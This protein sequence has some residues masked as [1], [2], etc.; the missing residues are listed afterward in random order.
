MP[1]WNVLEASPT[2]DAYAVLGQID[3]EDEE[4]AL[5]KAAQYY[6]EPKKSLIVELAE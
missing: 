2:F 4:E 5:N 1:L 3:A 6:E